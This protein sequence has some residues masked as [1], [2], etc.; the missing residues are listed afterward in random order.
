MGAH[1]DVWDRMIRNAQNGQ[2]LGNRALDAAGA[3]LVLEVA[4]NGTLRDLYPFTSG[5]RLCFAQTAT[6]PFE[7]LQP[8]YIEFN[9]DG[10]RAPGRYIVGDGPPYGESGTALATQD[11]AEAVRK[12]VELLNRPIRA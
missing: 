2:L 3:P 11:V 4:R 7:G 1:D 6:W 5:N 8:S 12:L 9:S 10:S